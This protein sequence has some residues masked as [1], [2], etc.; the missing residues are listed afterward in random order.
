MAAGVLLSRALGLLRD[1]VFAALLGAD[2]LTDEYVMAFA[3][4][5]WINYLLAGGYMAITFIPI[6]SRHLADD[7]EQGG[8]RAFTAIA[9]PV[10]IAM[11][12][13]VIIGMF[14]A[15]PVIDLIAPDFTPQQ[16][17]NAARLTRIVLPAQVFF[18]LGSLLMAVQYARERFAIPTLAPIVYNLGIIGGGVLFNV[19]SEEPTADGFAWGVLAGSIVGNFAIQWYGAHR[20][21]LRIAPGAPWKD[22]AVREYVALALPLMIGQS[23]VLLDEQLARSFGTLAPDGGVTWLQLARR[24]MLVP[25]GI[26]AQAAGVAAYP[27]LA[28][29]AAEGRLRELSAN[30]S[31]ALRYV[32][33]LSIGAAAG[34]A[35]LSVPIIRLLYER[36]LFDAAD[37]SGT[38]A[39]LVFFGLGVPLWGIQQILARGFY[40]R[41]QMW[42]PV[43]VGTGATAAAIPLYWLLFQA[44]EVRGLALASTI[45]IGIYTV[46]LAAIWYGRAGTEYLR[47]VARSAVRALPLAGLGGVAAWAVAEWARRALPDGIIGSLGAVLAGIGTF[48]VVALVAGA[49]LRDLVD[50]RLGENP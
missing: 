23:L 29:L 20:A 25:V 34:L 10:G 14:A 42:I 9:R 38:A 31:R 11:T 37:T 24:T 40:A 2:Q 30:L 12:A 15:R 32:V 27:Y 17:D 43:V 21:G 46:A 3:I 1:V 22:P 28:R 7:D 49:A 45:A 18:V 50:G 6:L 16:V 19:F 44:Y 4:P 33:V 36:N 35:A 5:D 39:A 47:P 13:L 41:R 48:F 26:I 8:W